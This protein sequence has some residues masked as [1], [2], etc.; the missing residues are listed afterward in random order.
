MEGSPA[1]ARVREAQVR[2]GV[3]VRCRLLAD[4]RPLIGQNRICGRQACLLAE[5]RNSA[6]RA[7]DS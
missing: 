2:K 4:E 6:E 5:A 3:K 1:A 7:V